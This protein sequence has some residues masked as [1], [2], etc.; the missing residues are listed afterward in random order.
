MMC[1]IDD[2]RI[3]DELNWAREK[4]E[5]PP[6]DFSSFCGGL[7][8]PPHSSVH[9]SV[10]LRRPPIIIACPRSAHA[11]IAS[12]S[13][14]SRRP[15][16]RRRH[17]GCRGATRSQGTR[18][19]H[20]PQDVLGAG[21]RAAAR[22]DAGTAVALPPCS[23]CR[24]N[25]RTLAHARTRF[26]AHAR[27]R[28][29]AHACMY[30]LRA[31]ALSRSVGRCGGADGA[32][33]SGRNVRELIS[34]GATGTP[35]VELEKGSALPVLARRFVMVAP[36]T[37]KPSR[38]NPRHQPSATQ[39]ASRRRGGVDAATTGGTAPRLATSSTSFS[40]ASRAFLHSTLVGAT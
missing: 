29:C 5:W 32:G 33:E 17:G 13:I 19:N 20:R 28:L 14:N 9:P 38:S 10:R 16:R 22:R 4:I 21:V 2:P 18:E 6:G 27:T 23:I 7:K 40:L 36:Q 31:P 12:A 24:P 26:C 25:R 34:P 30:L 11:A 35:P 1:A 3:P 8:Q 15:S 37:Y 39:G